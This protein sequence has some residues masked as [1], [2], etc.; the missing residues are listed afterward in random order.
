M[1][2]IVDAAAQSWLDEYV[3]QVGEI[4]LLSQ[5]E[6]QEQVQLLHGAGRAAA[7][8]RLVLSNLRFVVNVAR[9]YLKYGQAFVD[10]IQEGNVA[11]INAVNCFNPKTGERLR[12]FAMHWINGGIGQFVLENWRIADIG[13]TK[14]QCRLFVRMRRFKPGTTMLTPAEI[15][16]AAVYL[17]VPQE[18]IIRL[19]ERLGEPDIPYAK[20][21]RGI[22]HRDLWDGA[23]VG[24][25]DEI[26]FVEEA[27]FSRGRIQ[28]LLHALS[29][30]DDRA[31][32]IVKRRWLNEERK[33]RLHELAQ[34]YRVSGERVRQIQGQAF[35]TI[36]DLLR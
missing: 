30:L 3:R 7:V 19:E 24:H 33:E 12:S 31:Q 5:Q 8:Q 9:D 26:A 2:N 25:G 32:D 20:G 1:P 28:R 13:I 15:S 6:E 16:A 11:L 10:L 4:P 22:R 36:R 17:R 35:D 14:E 23:G 18:E 29:T 34:E 27:Q 21:T